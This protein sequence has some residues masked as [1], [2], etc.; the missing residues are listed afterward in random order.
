[1]NNVPSI[2]LSRLAQIIAGAAPLPFM[3]KGGN[4]PGR[5]I[6]ETTRIY[7]AERVVFGMSEEEKRAFLT[8]CN[9]KR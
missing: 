9:I 8:E 7:I 5:E 3:K 6:N 1:M 4:N 2:S